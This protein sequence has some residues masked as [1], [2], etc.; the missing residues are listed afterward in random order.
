MMASVWNP[1][2]VIVLVQPIIQRSLDHLTQCDSPALCD[3]AQLNVDI[4]WY[5]DLD[6]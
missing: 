1:D 3:D 2:A 5:G 4:F 6:E